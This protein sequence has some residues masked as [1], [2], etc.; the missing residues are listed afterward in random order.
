MTT[1]QNSYDNLVGFL[2]CFE[3][4]IMLSQTTWQMPTQLLTTFPQK[5]RGEK[6]V[7][8]LMGWDKD[9]E[10]PCQLLIQN[11][12]TGLREKFFISCQWIGDVKI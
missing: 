8:K 3:N 2:H 6:Y 11:L 9:R 1:Q 12:Q 4:K 5:D 7:K 10:I